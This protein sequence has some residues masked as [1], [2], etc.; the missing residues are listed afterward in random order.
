MDKCKSQLQM[1]PEINP[2]YSKVDQE[3]MRKRQRE[4]KNR[5]K[6]QKELDKEKQK[7]HK[8]KQGQ[9]EKKSLHIILTTL[10]E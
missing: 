1:R 5:K 7:E 2:K 9:K 8:D 4:R 3:N 6:K 10:K